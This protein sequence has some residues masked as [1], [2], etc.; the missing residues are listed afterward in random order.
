MGKRV[1]KYNTPESWFK[2][3]QSSVWFNQQWRVAIPDEYDVLQHMLDGN[4]SAGLAASRP[5]TEEEI[6]IIQYVEGS[7]TKW[8]VQDVFLQYGTKLGRYLNETEN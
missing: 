4:I 1:T 8:S 6:T 7:P 2:L 5:A 3:W